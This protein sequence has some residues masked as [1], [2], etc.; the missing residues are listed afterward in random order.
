MRERLSAKKIRI[1]HAA[2]VDLTHGT[3]TTVPMQKFSPS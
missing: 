3:R 2:V 1:G